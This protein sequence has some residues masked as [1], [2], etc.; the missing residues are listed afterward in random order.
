M[1]EALRSQVV[2]TASDFD[3]ILDETRGLIGQR[4][5]WARLVNGEFLQ[6]EIGPGDP[7]GR[8]W[9]GTWAIIVNARWTLGSEPP[10]ETNE[11][12]EAQLEEMQD[13]IVVFEPRAGDMGLHVR[14]SNGKA[15]SVS[16][17]TVQPGMLPYWELFAPGNRLFAIGPGRKWAE[18]DSREGY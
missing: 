3:A 12:L 16:P 10:G 8:D 1:S 15:L 17:D 11:E 18:L 2:R 7:E 4:C 13:V 14:F 6:L 9:R 5:Q